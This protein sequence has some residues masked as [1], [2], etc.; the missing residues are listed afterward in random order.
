VENIGENNRK[1]GKI[2]QIINQVFSLRPK[3]DKIRARLASSILSKSKD[4]SKKCSYAKDTM[5]G[6]PMM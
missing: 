5:E 4:R 1:V 3:H 2:G 6:R